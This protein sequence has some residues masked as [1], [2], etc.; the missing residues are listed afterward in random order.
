MVEAVAVHTFGLGGDSEVRLDKAEGL[1]VGPR[2]VV[3]L[4][5]LAHQHPETLD[6]LCSQSARPSA[7]RYD[8]QFALR[9]R[10]LDAGQRSL[11]SPQAEIWDALAQGPVSLENLFFDSRMAYFRRRAL[12]R[13]V[14]R[15]LV[16]VG[17]FTPTDAAHVL[18]HQHDWSVEAARLGAALW[19]RRASEP[20]W[21]L[22]ED[23]RD[24]CQRV[25]QQVMIQSGRSL[26]AAAL[27][28]A[29]GVDLDEHDLLRRLFVDR[30]L[31]GNDG[32]EESL[33]DVALTLR[34]ALVAIGAP[35]E[36]YY[37]AVAER[38]HTPLCI[39]QHA[40]V[41]NA[42]GAVAGGVM[43]TVRALIKPLGDG[44]FRV[45]LPIGIHDFADL[46]EA[47]AYAVEEASSLAEAQ[48]RRAGAVDV[49]VQT[50][51]KDHVFCP[52]GDKVYLGT[53]VTATA[54]GRPRL[55]DG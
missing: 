50:Q 2:R 13:L 9:Q 22:G 46:E 51:R 14:E 43:Q 24:F 47:A 29:Y 53:E 25:M 30:A 26:V 52:G 42:V 7:E 40:E 31:A 8:G 34:R 16:V 27:A 41:A 15:G 19:A 3:P 11:T 36:T 23:A 48:T 20:P 33:V 10:P 55:A 28:E 35:V 38:L 17:G 5:L 6:T 39:P 37:P 32:R 18:G 1:V 4:S 44:G 12:A 49:Q 54:V 45:H 21:E